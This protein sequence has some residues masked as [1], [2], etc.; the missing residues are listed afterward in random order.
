MTVAHMLCLETYTTP[1]YCEEYV[2]LYTR[3]KDNLFG[4]TDEFIKNI[5]NQLIGTVLIYSNT[6]LT[7][8]RNMPSKLNLLESMYSYEIDCIKKIYIEL[9]HERTD[10]IQ[11]YISSYLKQGPTNSENLY[12]YCKINIKVFDMTKELFNESIVSSNCNGIN[13]DIIIGGEI[14]EHIPEDLFIK[15]LNN[16]NNL[17]NNNGLMIF[18]TPNPNSL[19]V[20]FGKTKV[21]NDP[22]HVNILS[23]KKIKNI[24]NSFNFDIIKIEGSG[25]ASKYIGYSFPMFFYGSYLII[26]S[27]NKTI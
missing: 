15:M 7:I 3:L 20:K 27:K 12:S 18:T 8:N 17:L 13:F 4:Y 23:I 5:I 1:E 10:I 2:S 19:L 11:S 22:S 24:L 21:F 25:K 6:L 14:I 26:I 16:C 9:A